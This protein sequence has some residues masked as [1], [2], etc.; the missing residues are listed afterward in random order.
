MLKPLWV[1]TENRNNM[2][3]SYIVIH[4]SAT[5][6]DCS[7]DMIRQAHLKRGW[8]DI[9]YHY[10]I[11]TSG[12]VCVGRAEDIIGAHALGI[13]NQSLGICCIGNFEMHPIAEQQLQSLKDLVKRLAEK[14]Q[15]IQENIIGHCDV[16]CAEREYRRSACPG[17]FLYQH[18][19]HIRAYSNEI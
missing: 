11:E 13:N 6:S 19:D 18:I 7:V 17:K 4:H 8:Q 14:Y 15:I 9:G 1:A 2:I 12:T 3:P 5:E 10:V 16:T